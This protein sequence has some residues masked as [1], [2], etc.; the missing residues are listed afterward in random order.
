MN[1]TSHVG[2]VGL[3][4][5]K[6]FLRVQGKGKRFK[7]RHLIL[8]SH[9]Q[10]LAYARVGLTL[11]RHVGNAVTRNRIRR[12]LRTIIRLNSTIFSSVYDYVI[13][14]SPKSAKAKY[15]TIESELCY[16]L[17]LSKK[18]SYAPF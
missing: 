3:K 9:P 5:R 15:E 1:K 13:I 17:K 6:D 12:Q 8:L 14:A 2:V 7:S 11:S 16:L 18:T 4:S 10:T